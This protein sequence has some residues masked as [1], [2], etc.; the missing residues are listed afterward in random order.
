MR[1]A[2]AVAAVAAVAVPMLAAA[3]LGIPAAAAQPG[4]APTAVQVDAVPAYNAPGATA[5]IVPALPPPSTPPAAAGAAATYGEPE[6]TGIAR[7]TQDDAAADRAFFARTAL[8]APRG[9]ISVDLRAP[10][11]PALFGGINAAISDRFELGI[12]GLMIVEEDSL[13]GFH[14]KLQVYR[15]QR[16]ALAVGLDVI[17]N[18]GEPEYNDKLIMPSIAA[19]WCTD[20]GPACGTLLTLHVTGFSLEDEEEMPIFAG[21]SVVTGGRRKLV[22]ELHVNNDDE[23]GETL[24]GGYVGGRFGGKKF[25]FDAGLAFGGIS[26]DNDC[27]G[28]ESD[29][30][31]IP[32]PFVGLSSRL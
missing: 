16:A 27:D 19:S 32:F 28:C 17:H 31:L 25:A 11:G 10:T 20:G 12:G 22:A 1:P 18:E 8:I 21:V 14:G 5:P 7:R 6:L 23:S 2:A 13:L 29:S 30:E 9:T 4:A 3:A 24:F 15:G 26:D